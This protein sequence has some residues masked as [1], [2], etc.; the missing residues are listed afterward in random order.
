MP[1]GISDWK[2][3]DIADYQRRRAIVAEK[4]GSKHGSKMAASRDTGVPPTRV[5]GVLTGSLTNEGILKKLEAWI[6]KN[7]P[8]DPRTDVVQPPVIAL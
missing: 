7:M 4:L 2:P 8:S 5:S 3:A 6:E 1:K